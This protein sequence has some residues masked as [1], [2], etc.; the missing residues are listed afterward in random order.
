MSLTLTQVI[1]GFFLVRRARLAQTTQQN[2]RQCFAKLTAFCGPDT[3]FTDITT[4]DVRSFLDYLRQPP[5]DG[6]LGL[7]ERSVHDNLV[8]C[9]ALW[10]FAQKEFGYPH[11]VAAIDKPKYR[12]TTIV[13]FTL[14]EVRA[15]VQA[16]EWT[17]T[18]NA[19]SGKRTRSKRPTA[20]RDVAILLVLFDTGLRASELCDLCARDYQ[21]DNGRLHIRH[22]K[23][24]K[25]RYV[26]LGD[27]AQRALWRYVLERPRLK[28]NDPLF[29][30]RTSRPLDRNNLRHLLA[31]IGGNA[32][33][34]NVHPH[35]FRHTFA[36]QFLRNGGNIFELQRILGHESLDT[37]KLYLTLAEVDIEKA[38]RAH[39]P[40]D[41]WRL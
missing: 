5:S 4:A 36:I 17:A 2:Y 39:S 30:T 1:D 23:G 12:K 3:P 41:H 6:G 13:P 8:I 11:I 22:G 32:G 29:A 28:P 40:A 21:Q 38:Q 35:R 18:W 10:S 27:N 16:A 24:D 20:R 33:V 25:E 9:S 26:Y 34:P 31:K 19:K 14:E 15:I 37:V 7:S